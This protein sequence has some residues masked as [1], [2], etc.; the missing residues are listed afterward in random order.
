MFYLW[1]S[2]GECRI[3]HLEKDG[4]VFALR[5]TSNFLLIV[6]TIVKNSW[7]SSLVRFNCDGFDINLWMINVEDGF[8]ENNFT[9]INLWLLLIVGWLKLFRLHSFYTIVTPFWPIFFS[10]KLICVLILNDL[11]I[12]CLLLIVVVIQ[13]GFYKLS[14]FHSLIMSYF[15]LIVDFIRGQCK[16]ILVNRPIYILHGLVNEKRYKSSWRTI[17]IRKHLSCVTA[18]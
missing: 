15:H 2:N 16:N 9:L 1:L 7:E 3:N 8:C 4:G 18:Q 11:F 12:D 17:N 14:S 13:L 10:L 6:A 5:R